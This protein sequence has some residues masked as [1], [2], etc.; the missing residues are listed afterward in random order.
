M[1]YTENIK[2]KKINCDIS[3]VTQDPNWPT[4]VQN[5]PEKQPFKYTKNIQ[6]DRNATI[7]YLKAFILNV[8]ECP[9]NHFEIHYV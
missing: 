7:E 3:S 6:Y 2:I 1:S 5:Y 9:V 4:L 8:P